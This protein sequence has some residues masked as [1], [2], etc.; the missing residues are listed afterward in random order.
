MSVTIIPFLSL[1]RYSDAILN[2]RMPTVAFGVGVMTQYEKYQ[3]PVFSPNAP[4][5]NYL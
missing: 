2:L 3:L 5:Y 4:Q 1:F